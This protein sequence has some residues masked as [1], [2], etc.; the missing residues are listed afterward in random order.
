M[1]RQ[2][3]GSD[4]TAASRRRF[5]Q[6]MATAGGAA[7]VAVAAKSVAAPIEIED[8]PQTVSQ[9]YRVT[10]HIRDYYKTTRI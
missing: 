10:P 9:G 1:K 2:T 8:K 5:L 4:K 7:A 6:G 3:T